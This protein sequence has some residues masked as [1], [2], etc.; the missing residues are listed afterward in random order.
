MQNRIKTYEFLAVT[1]REELKACSV[2]TAVYEDGERKS[3]KIFLF[4]E[5]P[6]HFLKERKT[7]NS[8]TNGHSLGFLFYNY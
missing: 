7:T 8:S 2:T 6:Q 5:T 4:R 3:T 1:I